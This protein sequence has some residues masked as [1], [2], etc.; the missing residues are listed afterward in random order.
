ML[1]VLAGYFLLGMAVP[2]LLAF[3]CVLLHELAHTL[4]AALCGVE[5]AEV[6][7]FPFGGQAKMEEFTAMQPLKEVLIALA[8]PAASILLAGLFSCFFPVHGHPGRTWFVQVNFLLFTF[9]LLPALPLDGGRVLRALLSIPVGYRCS[10]RFTAGFGQA[11]GALLAAAGLWQLQ[12]GNGAHLLVIGGML[13]FTACRE[14]KFFSYQFLRLLLHQKQNLRQKGNLPVQPLICM[15]STRVR[16]IL[17][18]VRP[19]YY[20]MVTVVD[21]QQ[22]IVGKRSEV[23]L[24]QALLERGNRLTLLEALRQP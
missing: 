1:L 21:E 11:G 8:G 18:K 16:T 13:F 5:I 4:A 14:Q 24:I 17:E 22:R 6:Q 23:Q 20:L 10:T 12:Q 19:H 2:A 7:L 9:N 15:G 3:S